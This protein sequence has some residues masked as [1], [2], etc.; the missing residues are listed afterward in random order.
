MMMSSNARR[1]DLRYLE[2]GDFNQGRS[3]VV[4]VATPLCEYSLPIGVH[5]SNKSAAIRAFTKVCSC[6]WSFDQHWHTI[7]TRAE[8]SL[9]KHVDWLKENKFLSPSPLYHTKEE[10][11]SARRNATIAP[12]QNNSR[13]NATFSSVKASEGYLRKFD[14]T[15]D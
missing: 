15:T 10:K 2:P 4:L 5:E 8:P 3:G 12:T 11:R 9:K 7:V 6:L 1:S 13:S 14:A